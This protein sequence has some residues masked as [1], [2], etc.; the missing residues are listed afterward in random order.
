MCPKEGHRNDPK[1][2]HLP[3]EDRLRAGAVQPREEKAPGRPES[4]LSVSKGDCKKEGDRLFGRVCCDR[5]RGSGFKLKDLD[6]T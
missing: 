3:W 4:S 2:E 1:M 5:T 6:W